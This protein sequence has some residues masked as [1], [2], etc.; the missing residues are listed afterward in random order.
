MDESGLCCSRKHCPQFADDRLDE[1]VPV[2]PHQAARRAD[3]HLAIAAACGFVSPK[4]PLR[5]LADEDGVGEVNDVP[6]E[7]HMDCRDGRSGEAFIGGRHHVGHDSSCLFP[8]HGDDHRIAR[9]HRAVVH[10]TADGPVGMPVDAGNGAS[11]SNARPS[12]L[13]P[14]DHSVAKQRP[15]RL[16]RHIQISRLAVRQESVSHHL[17][18]G[19]HADQ[20]ERFAERAFEHRL[21]EQF[22]DPARLPDR[23]QPCAGRRARRLI[24]EATPRQPQHA[25][26]ERDLLHDREVTHGGEQGGQMQRSRQDPRGRAR[27][28]RAVG[29]D[30]PQ[31]PVAP[32]R[33]GDPGLVA[34]I[35][36]IGTAA[37][38]HVLT[39]IDEPP[40][41]GILERRG[42]PS[43]PA[44]RLQHRDGVPLFDERSGCSKPCQAAPDHHGMAWPPPR[45]RRLL[46]DHDRGPM[47]T[48]ASVAATSTGRGGRTRRV[49]TAAP[50]RF[51]AAK[52]D[53]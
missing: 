14:C 1:G 45:G 41:D 12:R 36:E 30:E 32:Q 4:Y 6:V 29:A 19:W 24:G 52:I 39:G 18:G 13:K 53:L 35:E 16:E 28:P 22:H 33:L 31:R 50:A 23:R 21:P 43:A 3:H 46:V 10:D 20:I 2:C 34:E 40:P 37:H 26:R 51:T 42:P 27:C 48:P 38:R 15:E 7:P 5:H 9:Q 17:S 11:C 47:A 8:R 25:G 44:P 49:R